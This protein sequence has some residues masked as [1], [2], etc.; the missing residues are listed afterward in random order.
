MNRTAGGGEF[1]IGQR[2]A[3]GAAQRGV[4]DDVGFGG[5]GREIYI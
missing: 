2:Q 3:S 1:K 4:D 5:D